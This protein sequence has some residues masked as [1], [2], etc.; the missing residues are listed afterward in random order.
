MHTG[1]IGISDQAFQYRYKCDNSL[2]ILPGILSEF[3]QEEPFSQLPSCTGYEYRLSS[4]LNNGGWKNFQTPTRPTETPDR[5]SVAVREAR[6]GP[7]D[8]QQV[9]LGD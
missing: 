5:G 9:V 1:I 3:T 8:F 7:A 6:P 4:G 2:S